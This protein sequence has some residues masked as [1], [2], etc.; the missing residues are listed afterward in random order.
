MGKT[1]SRAAAPSVAGKIVAIT[2]GARGIGFRTAQ[3][4]TEAGAVVAIGDVDADVVAKA[5]ADIGIDGGHVDVTDRA[6]FE[7]WLDGVQERLGPLDVLI[8]NAG[9]MPAGAFLDYDPALIRRTVEIDLL[10]VYTG[11]QLAARRMVDRGSGHIVN[12][13]SVAGRL[14]TPGLSIYNGVKA[15]VIEFSEALDAEL[16][17]L[18][19]RVSAVLPT[20]TRTG[21]IS[22]LRTNSVVQ[23]V[24]PDDVAEIIVKTIAQPRVRVTAPKTMAWVHGN[25]LI[26][27]GV[28]RRI[29]R[30]TGLDRMFLDY[31]TGARAEYTER[32]AR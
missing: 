2:G 12:I 5:A 3:L 25:T 13:A 32:I 16:L 15:G 29:R 30:S 31:D 7:G 10:G 1:W 22:G 20:F 21:L 27:A 24:E 26:G 4:L 28:K 23:A 19:V 6:S 18:G 11:S 14:P 8:N 17:P 9:I